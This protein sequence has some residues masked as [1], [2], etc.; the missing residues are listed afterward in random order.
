[1]PWRLGE[2]G[3]DT[4]VEWVCNVLWGGNHF[5]KQS[6]RMPGMEGCLLLYSDALTDIMMEYAKGEDMI[7]TL[8]DTLNHIDTDH[9]ETFHAALTGKLIEINGGTQFGDDLTFILLRHDNPQADTLPARLRD[10][11]LRTGRKM[12]MGMMK[13]WKNGL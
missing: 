1:M 2:I 4:P 12:M 10:T 3:H 5:V 9:V 6:F 13:W 11:L 7:H 8:C